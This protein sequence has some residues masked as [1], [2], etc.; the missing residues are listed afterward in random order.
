MRF[1]LKNGTPAEVMDEGNGYL[2][3][4]AD[5]SE[6]CAV[7]DA[8]HCYLFEHVNAH[9]SYIASLRPLADEPIA[10]DVFASYCDVYGC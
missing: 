10:A 3:V 7:L 9:P 1:K 5:G 4:F 8:G 6:S 2:I